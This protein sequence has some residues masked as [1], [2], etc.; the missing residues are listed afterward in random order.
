M[1]RRL[2]LAPVLAGGL[3]LG[4][5]LGGLFRTPSSGQCAAPEPQASSAKLEELRDFADKLGTLFRTVAENV[6]PSV[7]WIQSEQT[8]KYQMPASPFRDPFEDFFG[9]Q[10]RN[11]PGPQS[12]EEKRQGVGSGVI[13]DAGG[14]VLTNYHVVADADKLEVKLADGR[15]FVGKVAGTDPATELAVLKLEGSVK[16]LPVARLGDSDRL[17]V[18]EWVI[19]IGNPMG[20]SQSV[21]AGIV[22]AKGR[23]LGIAKYENLIQT[24]A[25]INPGNSG[26]PLVNLRGEVVGINTA[27]VS[28]TG[29]YMGIGMAIPI[30]MAKAILDDLKAGK[31]V[32]RGFLGIVGENLTKEAADQFSYKGTKGAVVNEVMPNTPAA[33]AGLKVDDIIVAWDGKDVEDFNHLRQ[34]VAATGPG[35]KVPLKIWRDGKEETREIEVARQADHEDVAATNW[36]GIQVGP[37]TDEIRDRLGRKDLEGAVVTKVD[38]KGP[39]AMIEPGDVIMSV[40]RK[41]VKNVVD[42]REAMAATKPE[43]GA[44]LRVL[45]QRTGYPHRLFIGGK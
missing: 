7:V 29:G 34:L 24:D 33:K 39:A 26:G 10:F 19:A 31:P 12:R 17:Y 25:A 44:M 35:K 18:G 45:D 8:V 9:P 3:A 41:I 32:E 1:T 21:S 13:F 23:G 14:Y 30:N 27:I 36:L 42:F 37:V 11:F 38:P 2:I 20:L 15:T 22:S 6:S 43:T 28:N 5:A 40:N 4:L 16:D